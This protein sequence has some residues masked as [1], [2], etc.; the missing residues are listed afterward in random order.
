MTSQPIAVVVRLVALWAARWLA[1]QVADIGYDPA[2]GANIGAGLLAFLVT[3]IVA[4]V[5]AGIDARRSGRWGATLLRWLVVGVLLGVASSFQAQG[6]PFSGRGLDT[7]VLASDLR[8]LTPFET[9]LVAVPAAIGV[10]V[11]ML[12]RRRRQP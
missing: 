12:A 2:G 11:G 3:M 10:A 4:L 9:G 1:V 6:F 5:W 7:A 8:G